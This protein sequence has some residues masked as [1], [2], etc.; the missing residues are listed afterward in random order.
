MQRNLHTT[1]PPR[2]IGQSSHSDLVYFG[3]VCQNSKGSVHSQSFWSY[4]FFQAWNS[5][6]FTFANQRPAA[7]Q[8]ILSAHFLSVRKPYLALSLCLWWSLMLIY[9]YPLLNISWNFQ[10]AAPKSWKC[11]KSTFS[12]VKC[13]VF[14][15]GSESKVAEC[16]VQHYSGLF[17]QFCSI[18]LNFL[19]HFIELITQ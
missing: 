13:L 15:G 16:E 11:A 12:E 8:E 9:C 5:I 3:K 17:L 2:K 4:E 19:M 7:A 6:S 10:R 14:R 1:K 18:M